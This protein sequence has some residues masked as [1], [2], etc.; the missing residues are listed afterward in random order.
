M[1]V[2]CPVTGPPAGA[3]SAG[4]VVGGAGVVVGGTAVSGGEVVVVLGEEVGGAARVVVVT[5]TDWEVVGDFFGVVRSAWGALTATVDGEPQAAST[6][7]GRVDHTMIRRA[8]WRVT[9]V[10]LYQLGN[11]TGWPSPRRWDLVDR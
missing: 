2:T 1:A 8:M 4:S 9:T 10:N 3:P 6:T 11:G 7:R 5:G